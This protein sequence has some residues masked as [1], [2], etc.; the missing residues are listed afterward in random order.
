MSKPANPT[1]APFGS[2]FGDWMTT[3][4]YADGTYKYSG[5]PSPMQN[6]SIHPASHVLHYSSTCFEGLKAHRQTDGSLAIFRL[7][8]HVARMRQS[9]EKL[10]VKSADADLIRTMIIDAVEANAK[11]TPEPPGSLYIRPAF[12]GTLENV[13]AAA[14]PTTTGLLYVLNSPVGDYFKGGIRPLSLFIETQ[15]PRTTPAFGMVKS[16][17]NYALALGPTLEAKEKYGVDQVL[18]ATNNDLTETGAANFFLIDDD[19]IVTRNLDESFLHGITRYSI[20]TLAQDLGYKVEERKIGVDELR[21]W[22][23]EAF[24]SGTA[25]VLSP[26]GKAVTT[27]DEFLFGDGQPGPNSLKLRKALTEVQA[28]IAQDKHNWLTTVTG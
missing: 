15:T 11:D 21:D 4:T 6:L 2:V 3:A 20:I 8:D 25:A 5:S 23:G 19:K 10:Q 27:E 7:D 24:L 16:G 26:V 14:A 9:L 28:G 13:G 1:E 17:A 22:Q 12:V 18:F